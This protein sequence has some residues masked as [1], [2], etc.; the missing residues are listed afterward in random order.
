[1]YRALLFIV[2][3]NPGVWADE[4]STSGVPL[5]TGK[6]AI[7]RSQDEAY[8]QRHYPFY[9]AYNGGLSKVQVSFKSPIVR[10]TP[11]Y[12]GYTQLMFWALRDDSKPFR[13]LTY[14]PELF[15]RH[16]FK[17][18]GF[19]KSVDLGLWNHTSNGK[20][21]NESRSFDKFYVRANLEK[22]FPRWVMGFFI[23]ASELYNF[24]E[25]NRNIDEFISPLSVGVSFVQVFEAWVDKSEFSLQAI[26]GGRFAEE[27]YRGGYQASLSFRLGGLDIVPAFYL[28]YYHGYAETLL[29]YADKVDVFRA[30][31]IF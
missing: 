17:N 12:F 5:T 25:G 7:L 28:Q 27:V 23:Q 29:N 11:L 26:P 14:N 13:D 1:M 19:L 8:L 22:E 21:G 2:I 18:L 30:G 10:G 6:S 3:W 4:V 9:F 31:F 16:S 24:D 15:Y 20:A